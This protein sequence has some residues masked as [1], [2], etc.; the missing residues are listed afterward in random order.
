M[1]S[2]IVNFGSLGGLWPIEI[3]NPE[4]ERKR[5][6]PGYRSTSILELIFASFFNDFSVYFSVR[7]LDH[8]WSDFGAIWG[9]TMDLKS[10]KIDSK[11][12]RFFCWIF[13]LFLDGVWL[14][15]GAFWGPC[16]LKNELL[17]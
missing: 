12:D 14:I 11:F 16:T 9:A 3:A 7:F 10:L 17:V 1:G 8:F 5:E 2:K 15:L 4:K 6:L 13:D